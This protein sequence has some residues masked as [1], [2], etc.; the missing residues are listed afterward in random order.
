MGSRQQGRC[1]TLI[2]E[3]PAFKGTSILIPDNGR[4]HSVPLIFGEVLF[5]QFLGGS[6]V[7]G[8]APFNVAWHLQGLGLAPLLISAVG[9]DENGKEALERM[10]DW[11]MNTQAVQVDP[12]HPTG[13]VMA[14]LVDGEAAFEIGSEQA[15]DYIDP[16]QATSTLQPGASGSFLYHGTLAL[17]SDRSWQALR[18]LR[19]ATRAPTFV[20]LNL[21]DPWWSP[22]RVRWCLDT[23]SWLK[24]SEAELAQV[25]GE[26]S[27]DR[28]ACVRGARR[29]TRTHDIEVIFVTLGPQGALAVEGDAIVQV[30]AKPLEQDELVDTVGAGDAFSAVACAGLEMGWSLETLLDRG[31]AFAADICRVRGAVVKDRSLYETRRDA[32]GIA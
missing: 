5:D 25:A 7:L 14:T 29:L 11:G 23:A 22:D 13:R 4:R 17:R 20:D 6:R 15:Y 16:Q 24:V 9:D 31:T 8:G 21:R 26:R 18:T 1:P 10:S 27:T 19:T 32:W 30:P 12:R 28:D 2:D 3:S